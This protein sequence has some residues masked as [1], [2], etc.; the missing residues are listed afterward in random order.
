MRHCLTILNL[1]LA[2]LLSAALGRQVQVTTL[3]GVLAS[4]AEEVDADGALILRTSDG[5]CERILAGDVTLR[6]SAPS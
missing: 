6:G 2:F 5:Q 4:W 3:Q 1:M